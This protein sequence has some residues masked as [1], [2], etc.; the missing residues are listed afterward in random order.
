MTTEA[1]NS[2]NQAEPVDFG[3]AGTAA[4]TARPDMIA[5]SEAE[6]AFRERDEMKRRARKAE[7]ERDAMKAR[8]GEQ[9]LAD[10]L[11]KLNDATEQISGLTAQLDEARATAAES[12]RRERAGIV[13]QTVLEQIP[14]A[15]RRGSLVAL[16][17][18][19]I[20]ALSD[21]GEPADIAAHVVDAL[22]E[23]EPEAFEAA[24]Q[25]APVRG[26]LP[27]PQPLQRTQAAVYAEASETYQRVLGRNIRRAQISGIK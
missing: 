10:A 11:A 22:R 5:R 24:K 21:D 12:S 20:E 8:D 4:D 19:R 17:D 18:A 23:I 7:A 14:E 1:T 16:L 13:R 6:A 9:A 3:E 25:P 15:N 26:V 27:T 2:D